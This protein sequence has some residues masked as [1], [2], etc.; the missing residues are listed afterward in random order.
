M[1]QWNFGNQHEFS[2]RTITHITVRKNALNVML[3]MPTL[4][5]S[6]AQYEGTNSF[7]I[8][9][10]FGERSIFCGI[11]QA[12]STT[13][14]IGPK[15][16]LKKK[17]KGCSQELVPIIK[18][19]GAVISG[20]SSSSWDVQSIV[21]CLDKVIPAVTNQVCCLPT[22]A[23]M[24]S[25]VANSLIVQCLCSGYVWRKQSQISK[26]IWVIRVVRKDID[27]TV[28]CPGTIYGGIRL[29]V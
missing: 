1:Y 16:I 9:A 28:R 26:L 22:G 13:D 7:S 27:S 15:R 4:S 6:L 29:Y 11:E 23:Q 17:W 24:P 14:K 2:G 3:W 8:T 10:L 19:C 18:S 20:V 21:M 25:G 12:V 5:S